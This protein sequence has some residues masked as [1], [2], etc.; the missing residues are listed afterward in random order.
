M[1]KPMMYVLCMVIGVMLFGGASALASGYP[2]A[3]LSSSGPMPTI[4]LGKFASDNGQFTQA[5]A[6][7]LT[8]PIAAILQKFFS[9][10]ATSVLTPNQLAAYD[11]DT[12]KTLVKSNYKN[13]GYSTY[14]FVNI[15]KTPEY[16]AGF[17]PNVRQDIYIAD[18][19]YLV[20]VQA[21]YL[22]VTSIEQPYMYLT[23]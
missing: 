16:A 17:G 7:N 4:L 8:A 9:S 12:L 20:N 22:Y 11:A 19:A 18:K 23:Y 15:T 6:Q 21:D 2:F 3:I 1:K 10:T 5:E 13:W 14:T